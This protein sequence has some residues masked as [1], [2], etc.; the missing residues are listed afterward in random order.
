[1]LARNEGCGMDSVRLVRWNVAG[2]HEPWRELVK[3]GVNVPLLQKPAG[4]LLT[5]LAGSTWTRTHRGSNISSAY[6]R[7]L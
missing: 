5:L 3:M 6:G 4:S 2:R 1:M 7:R